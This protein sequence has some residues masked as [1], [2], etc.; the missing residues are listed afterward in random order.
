MLGSVS[1]W[2]R[3]TPTSAPSAARRMR[4]RSAPSTDGVSL[5]ALG[6]HARTRG[7]EVAE[8]VGSRAPPAVGGTSITTPPGETVATMGAS[9]VGATAVR[10]YPDLPGVDGKKWRLSVQ[11]FQ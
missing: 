11:Y 2:V 5:R 4:S 7:L 8:R 9:I 3:A 6:V 1:S 10:V